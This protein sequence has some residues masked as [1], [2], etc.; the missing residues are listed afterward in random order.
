MMKPRHL[1]LGALL[2]GAGWLAL[3]GDKS[4][5]GEVVAPV[6]GVAHIA[7]GDAAHARRAAGASPAIQPLI[8][9]A[10]LLGDAAAPAATLFGRHS[11]TPPPPPPPPVVAAPPPRP[12][13]PPLPFT[14]LGRKQQNGKWEAYLARGGET[15]V[16][17][18]HNM[19]DPVYRAEAITQSAITITYLPLKQV[20]KLAIGGAD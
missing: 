19:I 18:E 4:P 20:Q 16:V 2:L 8:D 1:A 12:A 6:A 11:W 15:Y 5:R 10:E 3:F 17:T 14:Y 9:R 7:A 13:A